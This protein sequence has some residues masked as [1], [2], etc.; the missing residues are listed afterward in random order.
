MDNLNLHEGIAKATVMNA[1]EIF[2]V[3]F[4]SY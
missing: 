4:N 2:F 3:T 1:C